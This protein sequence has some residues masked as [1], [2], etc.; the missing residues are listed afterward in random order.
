MAL[1]FSIAVCVFIHKQHP[2]TVYRKYAV[3]IDT[4]FENCD[5]K[6]SPDEPVRR[7]PFTSSSIFAD[8]HS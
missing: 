7:E 4:I 3:V 2:Q 8:L 5:K 1:P 6:L